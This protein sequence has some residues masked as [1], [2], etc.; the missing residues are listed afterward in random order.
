MKLS[1][2][3]DGIGTPGVI[4]TPDPLLRSKPTF[5]HTLHVFARISY[6]YINSGNLL[7]LK[8]TTHF[9]TVTW[10]REEFCYG[11]VTL[12]GE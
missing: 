2:F 9:L 10:R 1:D 5:L 8:S 12:K 11:F 3:L 4:R 7:S 6:L